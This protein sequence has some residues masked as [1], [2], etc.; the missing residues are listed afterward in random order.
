LNEIWPP[1]LM[2]NDNAEYG[3]VVGIE[4]LSLPQ[5]SSRFPDFSEILRGQT[6][7]HR[8]S[9]MK[10]IP[11]FHRTYFFGILMQFGLRRSAAVVS[12]QIHFY[13]DLLIVSY[14]IIIAAAYR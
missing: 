3:D 4:I 10:R 1:E 12:S 8:I 7:F 11:M 9:A 13:V 6:V 2:Q 14:R 5:L